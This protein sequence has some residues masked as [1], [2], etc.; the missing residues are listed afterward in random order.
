MRARVAQQRIFE[1]GR[2]RLGTLY[3]RTLLKPGD[4][5]IGPAVIAE[6]SA[7]T[8]LP[9]GW[10]ATV[11]PCNNLMLTPTNSPNQMRRA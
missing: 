8:Y 2:W 10:T 3:D 9:R 4:K 7:T 11:D 5:F 6:L 1:E